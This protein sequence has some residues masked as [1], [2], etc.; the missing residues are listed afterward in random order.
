M[1][2]ASI[3]LFP[4]SLLKLIQFHHFVLENRIT[5][6]EE[7]S[8]P[9]CRLFFTI[10]CWTFGFVYLCICV[11]GG[12]GSMGVLF[13]LLSWSWTLGGILASLHL[14]SK[15]NALHTEPPSHPIYSLLFLADHLFS[16]PS[17]FPVKGFIFPIELIALKTNNCFA[18]GFL[19][20]FCTV[21]QD[22]ISSNTLV[23]L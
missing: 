10:Y 22:R 2:K 15:H 19:K 4:T 12:A 3:R 14:P 23:S 20:P 8:N 5:S 6:Y 1:S 13:G 9:S 18:K 17:V 16:W 11:F 7:K 21:F